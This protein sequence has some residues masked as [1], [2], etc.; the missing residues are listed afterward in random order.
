MKTLRIAFASRRGGCAEDQQRAQRRGRRNRHPQ[1][2]PRQ[3]VLPR[4]VALRSPP[5]SLAPFM[6][7]T[8]CVCTPLA[9]VVHLPMR[10]PAESLFIVFLLCCVILVAGLPSRKKNPTALCSP[11][12]G[13]SRPAEKRKR[14][15]SCVLASP[16]SLLLRES[17]AA[18]P[19]EIAVPNDGRTWCWCW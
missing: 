3:T 6:F 7:D 5:A 12:H 8:W 17:F 14:T 1:C 11:L 2:S 16:E 19:C 9:A 18:V 10:S 13:F 4:F 15:V